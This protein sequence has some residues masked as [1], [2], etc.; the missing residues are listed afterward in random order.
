MLGKI[1]I[2]IMTGFSLSACHRSGVLG[3]TG[4]PENLQDVSRTPVIRFSQTGRGIIEVA[5]LDP[6]GLAK[7]RRAEMSPANWA[8][9]FAISPYPADGPDTP[10]MLGSYDVQK[11]AIRF[12]PRFPLVA[13][14]TYKARF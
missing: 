12:T 14:L 7:L 4:I 3:S 9:L 6:M 5:G 1:V 13:G 2:L 10:A 11:D 8:S